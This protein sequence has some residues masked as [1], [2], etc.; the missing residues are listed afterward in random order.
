MQGVA[1]VGVGPLAR[2]LLCQPDSDTIARMDSTHVPR[3]DELWA[4]AAY[5]NPSGYE[6]RLANY[7]TFRAH[8]SV[9]LATVELAFDGPFELTE[10]DADILIQI[11][12]GDVMWQK[13]RLLNLALSALPPGCTKVVAVDCDL[14][15]AT[16]DWADRVRAMLEEYSLIQPFGRAYWMPRG[17]APGNPVPPDAELQRS[18]ACL[19]DGGMTVDAALRGIGNDIG[20][21]HG[22][23]W[24]ARRSL[25]ED[26]GFYD[27]NVVGGGDTSLFRAAYGYI[28]LLV[29]RFAYDDRRARHYRNWAQPFYA[30]VKGEVGYVAADVYHLWHGSMID[31]IYRERQTVLAALGFDAEEDVAKS[32]TGAW[33]WNSDKPA[34]HKYLRDY[35][36]AR[37]E[38]G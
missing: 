8:L 13:E 1:N 34:L 33:R 4:I 30:S 10:G 14:V 9:P 37:S 15:F 29:E 25:L 17:W 11:R 32:H 36:D 38:D 23:A 16:A 12:G 24:A 28:E 7:R 5:Y 2:N 22:L 21:A 27:A 31:R 35:F 6:R 3:Q 18:A 19:I 20:C 26:H